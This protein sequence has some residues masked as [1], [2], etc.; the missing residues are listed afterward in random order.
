MS[1]ENAA[2]Q[3][4]GLSRTL[5]MA[6]GRAISKGIP[7]EH[8]VVSWLVEHAAFSLSARRLKANGITAHQH[9]R[10]RQFVKSSM[11]FGE[12]CPWKLTE[13]GPVREA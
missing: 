8:P 1:V 13:K 5:K 2:K 7:L 11:V 12:W 4:Q 10:G 6:L 3:V 9:L